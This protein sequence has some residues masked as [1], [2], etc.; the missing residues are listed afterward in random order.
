[1]LSTQNNPEMAIA[2][3]S[4]VL[5]N[6]RSPQDQRLMALLNRADQYRRMKKYPEAIADATALAKMPESE[7]S[8]ERGKAHLVLALCHSEQ[9]KLPAAI[10]AVRRHL[11]E[12]VTPA[13]R[14]AAKKL[15]ACKTPAQ[16]T[17]L[18][19]SLL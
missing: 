15:A 12:R 19:A 16:L 14:G 9:G 18:I 6:P 3:W 5:S 8:P 13:S 4:E 7:G 10:A 11:K 17:K 2:D 1:M